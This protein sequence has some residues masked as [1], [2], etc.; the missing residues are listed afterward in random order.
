[1]G[2]YY[3]SSVLQRQFELNLVRSASY[4]LSISKLKIRLLALQIAKRDWVSV[5]KKASKESSIL[6]GSLMVS[7]QGNNALY[8]TVL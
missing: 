1:M 3:I 4:S 5:P 8:C 7:N 2:K 6:A